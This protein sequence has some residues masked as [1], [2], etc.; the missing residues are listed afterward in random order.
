MK[1]FFIKLYAQYIKRQV[2]FDAKH[3]V[4][5]QQKIFSLLV[6]KAK[7]T[8]FGKD[9]D[10]TR[11]KSYNDYKSR[12]PIRS[13]EELA[14]Y[15]NRIKKG[16]RNV[17]WPGLPKYFAKTSGTTSGI[18]YIPISSQ[19]ITKHIEA[20]RNATLNFIAQSEDYNLF[21]GKVIFLSGS[22]TL[23]NKANISIG[24]L[25]GIVNHEIPFWLKNNQLPNYTTNC[26]EDW[27]AKLDQIIE[28]TKDQD[29]RL[30]SGIPP[31]V[32]MYFERLLEKTKKKTV[33]EV[34]PNFSLFAYG[35]VNYE[36]YRN[37]I[38]KLIGRKINSVE[39]YPA[40]EGF[41]AF[42]DKM[43]ADGL[44]LNTNAMMYYEFVPLENIYDANPQ[45][46]SLQDVKLDV[47]YVILISS[48]AGL[49]SYNLGDTIRFVST[50]PYRIIVSG[51][52]NHFISAFGE[53]VIAKEVEESLQMA[54]ETIDASVIEFT[55][56]PQV[57]PLNK[58]IP[59]HEW[60]IEFEKSPQN[61]DKFASDLDD[62]MVK[63]NIYYKDLI[64]GS[65]LQKLKI[66]SVPK[67]TFQNYM[68]SIGKLGGQN[69]VPRLSN[70]RK[71][72][73]AITDITKS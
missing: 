41:I 45:R 17:L 19:S 7:H 10:F 15:I 56:A 47:D 23:Q 32:Q 4:R 28:E 39:T 69:K 58:Q 50:S 44:L 62:Q 30:I 43:K 65:I 5:H 20:A 35:G 36:P 54:C 64:D 29:L 27:E 51:R 33:L 48:N 24:R 67:G 34:F 72:A 42:Q 9:H 11:I 25:S 22:P 31:W 8:A 61:I 66:R 2:A 49:W 60:F 70:D 26:I 73:D 6:D 68:K 18:K 46:L 16:E 1:S 40:S 14:L 55:V 37:S 57:N 52:V 53:H 71:I 13:Y 21:N 63:Q 12:V 3:A 38:E 59:Y